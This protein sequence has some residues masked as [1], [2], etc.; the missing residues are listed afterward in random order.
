MVEMSSALKEDIF[1]RV[2][3]SLP[4]HAADIFEK[5]FTDTLDSAVSIDADGMA[6][7]VTGDI[8]AMWLRDSTWQLLPYLHFLKRDEGL[9]HLAKAVSRK[10]LSLILLDPYA[11][12]FNA[13]PDNAGHQDDH[14]QMGPHIW[15]RKYEVDSLCSPLFLAYRIW[16]ETG[17]S[18]HLDGFCAVLREV[19]RV[20]RVEQDHEVN[21][22]YSF[23]RP[24][25]FKQSDT[26]T[27][28]GKG[29]KVAPTGMTWSAFRPSDDATV[30]GYNIP[31]NAFAV[32]SLR[33]AAEIVETVFSDE[34]LSRDAKSL[35]DEIEKGILSYGIVKTEE[36]GDVLAYEVDGEGNV[37]L[38]DDAN[39]PSLLSL[40][41]LGWRTENDALYLNTRRMIL[42][43]KNPYWYSGTYATGIGSPH[44]PD[45][46]V[47]PIALAAQGLTSTSDT[48]KQ[49][50]LK[51][52][53][54][55]D[56]GTNLMHE[57]FDVDDPQRYTRPWFS[58]ANAMYCEFVL[59][60]VGKS[61]I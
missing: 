61:L 10:Q 53:S 29:P 43:E 39:L 55:N 6:F 7:V 57:S 25:P 23:E 46:Y 52:L 35:A 34:E 33:H 16:K 38:A 14:T 49:A 1:R 26:L 56:A 11:N 18:D 12:A 45:R 28:G 9:A 31:G 2:R 44:T 20:W 4:V 59:S 40:P 27:R 48:E 13:N 36:W 41:F 3:G 8:P 24:Q 54:E 5:C 32:V 22:Q 30:Y 42:S 15:E 50:L 51:M 60:L 47:W 17:D 37:L 21:S 19:I 58:W